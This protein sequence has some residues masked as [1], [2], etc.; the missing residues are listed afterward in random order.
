M[1]QARGARGIEVG[2]QRAQ[3][4]R[5]HAPSPLPAA[6]Q[7]QQLPKHAVALGGHPQTCT[8][9]KPSGRAPIAKLLTTTNNAATGV[10]L[11]ASGPQ[12]CMHNV[13]PAERVP[14]ATALSSF[15]CSRTSSVRTTCS[16][17]RLQVKCK[18]NY[19]GERSMASGTCLGQWR[20]QPRSLGGHDAG[21]DAHDCLQGLPGKLCCLT[22][23]P[24]RKPVQDSIPAPPA[25]L[26][27]QGKFPS[28]GT[29]KPFLGA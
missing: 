27:T 15:A 23:G 11:D 22:P 3:Q 9:C 8:P 13:S 26:L 7:H 18:G 1:R 25:M 20:G 12:D 10:L 24:W 14:E 5:A 19:H 21:S 16:S 4:W 6:Q 29:C 2:Q 17:A 28:P